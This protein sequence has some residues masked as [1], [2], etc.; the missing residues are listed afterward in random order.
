MYAFR[1]P[2][3]AASFSGEPSW[4]IGEKT[5]LVTAQ[6]LGYTLAKILG[7]RVIAETP[8]SR[9]AAGIL[10]LIGSAELALLLFGVSPRPIRPLWLFLNGLSLGM[11]FGLVLGFLEG[12]RLTEALTA[13]LCASFILADGVTKSVGTWLLDDQGVP[14][15]WMPARGG[16]DVPR[17]A[18]PVRLDAREDSAARP[19][20]RR[21]SG[22]SGRR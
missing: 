6:V 7:I 16:L 18:G 17:A 13:G 19:G 12:R 2:F 21:A 10:V 11:V 4:G 1:K 9:R 5:L 3:T 14:E 8:A 20:R 15:R 22:A